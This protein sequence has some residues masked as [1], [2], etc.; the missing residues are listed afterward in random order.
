MLMHNAEIANLFDEMAD[1]LALQEENPFRI[2][3]YRRAA[4]VIRGLRSEL[5]EL[6]ERG[7]DLDALPGIGPD[8]AAK[9]TELV[10]TGR[11]KA[12]ERL[13]RK[14][15]A[16]LVELLRLPGLGP[17]RVRALY[18]DLKVRDRDGL[19][20]AVATGKLSRI[21]GFGP[22][23][24]ERLGSELRV[25]RQAERRWLRSVAAQFAEPLA[26]HLRRA[27]GVK[28]VVIAGSYRRG[29][30]TVGDI[31]LLVCSTDA[32]QVVKALRAYDE[33]AKWVASGEKRLTIVLRSGL[34]VD[35]RIS[36][37]DCFGAALHYFTGSKAH[38]IHIRGIARERGLKINEY[39][40]FRGDRLLAGDTEESVFAAVKLPWIPPEIREDQGEIEAAS[41]GRLPSLVTRRDLRGDLHSHTSAS[42]GSESLEAMARAARAAG[43]DYLAITDHSRYLGV[44]KGQ[45]ARRLR[46]QMESI[47][48]LNEKLDGITLLKGAEVDILEDGKLALPDDVLMELDVVIGAVHSHFD[49][50]EP[51]QT[52][53]VL[54][55]MEH[56]AFTILS[57]PLTRLLGERP[58]VKLNLERVCRAAKSRPC[59]LELD[60]QPQRLDLDEVHCRMAREHG[61][62]VSIAS[63][64]HSGAQFENLDYGV[65]QAR[66]GWLT[67][68]DVLNSRRLSELRPLLRST[69]L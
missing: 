32:A 5:T 36:D 65:I 61:V 68:A 44:V 62:L 45:D 55:A 54:R 48:R 19:A 25:E 60:A 47:D 10:T 4:Q 9:I 67:A 38:N 42:D 51:K 18:E 56:R 26:R 20:R 15:P 6:V 34:Q 66:R 12:A 29:R 13:R 28:E 21:R 22:K 64:A 1:L 33:V 59:F 37:P 46:R 30:E 58:A 24:I 52:A 3:A 8:L 17:K 40:V 57:H 43:L 11:S 35:V 63:D 2:R 39:G 31:D 7:E 41:S 69:F 27:R 23:L 16:G 53:R 14:V 49:L 50:S